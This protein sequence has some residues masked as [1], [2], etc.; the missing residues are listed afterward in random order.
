MNPEFREVWVNG[1]QWPEFTDL[2]E[3]EEAILWGD[4]KGYYWD[5]QSGAP[6][7]VVYLNLSSV[8]YESSIN[9]LEIKYKSPVGGE[10][11]A[12]RF[13]YG[14]YSVRILP[15]SI[16]LLANDIQVGSRVTNTFYDGFNT[17][18]LKATPALEIVDWDWWNISL[19]WGDQQ[20]ILGG[21]SRTGGYWFDEARFGFENGGASYSITGAKYKLMIQTT[22][23]GSYIS[24]VIDT[25]EGSEWE[26]ISWDAEVPAGCVVKLQTRTGIT[27]N[28]D[29]IWSGWSGYY[30]QSGNSI[31]SPS[32]RYI[33]YRV[34]LNSSDPKISPLMKSVDIDY[35]RDYVP[36]SVIEGI[37]GEGGD[38]FI[39]LAWNGSP[40]IDTA[41]YNIYRAASPREKINTELVTDL[42]YKDMGVTNGQ[43][44]SYWITALDINGNESDFQ[45]ES[46]VITAGDGTPP[47]TEI[48]IGE[49]FEYPNGE[50]LMVQTF[51]GIGG[52]SIPAWTG[53]PGWGR[54]T[55]SFDRIPYQS[56]GYMT[57]IFTPEPVIEERQ[58][59]PGDLPYPIRV[60]IS[61]DESDGTNFIIREGDWIELNYNGNET[62]K[63]FFPYMELDS[64]AI[65]HIVDGV[66]IGEESNPSA[67]SS[68]CVYPSQ[69]GSTYRDVELTQIAY[70]SPNIILNIFSETPISLA[71]IDSGSEVARIEYKIDEGAWQVYN[72]AFTLGDIA[73]GEYIIYY[74]STDNFDNIEIAKSKR[75]MLKT[76]PPLEAITDLTSKSRENITLTWTA[77]G[78]DGTEG[79][80]SGYILKYSTKSI[81]SEADFVSAAVYPQGWTPLPSGSKE[82]KVLTDFEIGKR[83]YFAITAINYS[84][85]ASEI[86]NVCSGVA[87]NVRY[88]SLSGSDENDGLTK[89]QPLA[90]IQKA[91]DSAAQGTKVV[92]TEGTYYDQTVDISTSIT[93]GNPISIHGSGEVILDGGGVQL[94]AFYGEGVS[95][96][97]ISDIKFKGYT[98]A[99]INII[100]S[101][102]TEDII[103]HNIK[104]SSCTFYELQDTAIKFSGVSSFT[105]A[106]NIFEMDE[107]KIAMFPLYAMKDVTIEN[108]IC[109]RSV[110][111]KTYPSS[112]G[113]RGDGYVLGKFVIK[114]NIIN[115]L[116]IGVNWLFVYDYEAGSGISI[117]GN[118]IICESDEYD[119]TGICIGCDGA[120]EVSIKDNYI[121]NTSRDAMNEGTGIKVSAAAGMMYGEIKRNTV[122]NFKFGICNYFSNVAILNNTV[123]NCSNGI[124]AK[125]TMYTNYQAEV[126]NNIV[127][128]YELKT[129]TGIV[130]YGNSADRTDVLMCNLVNNYSVPV[131]TFLIT[132]V[133]MVSGDPGFVDGG[134]GDCRLTATSPCI[135]AGDPSPEYNDPDGT[136]C[137]I[138]AYYY[139]YEYPAPEPGFNTRAGGNVIVDLDPYAK[140]SF[141]Y[142]YEQG[143]TQAV[144]TAIPT[145]AN[146][147]VVPEN[148]GYNITTSASF[149]GYITVGIKYPDEITGGKENNLKLL[150]QDGTEWI[151]IT[152]A[153]D[154]GNNI[155]YGKVANLSLFCVAYGDIL[156]PRTSLSAGEPSYV[157]TQTIYITDATTF[158]LAAVD[159]LLNVGDESGLGVAEIRYRIGDNP[160][161]VYTGTLSV[162]GEGSR[163]IAYYSVDNMGNTE[164]LKTSNIVVDNSP[165][166]IGSFVA[167]P[168]YFSPNGDGIKDSVN[169]TAALSEYA[170]WT[171]TIKNSN[172]TVVKTLTGNGE[173]T[174]GISALWSPSGLA[175]GDYSINIAVTDRLGNYTGEFQENFN[176]LSDNLWTQGHS[177]GLSSYS[178]SANGWLN[179]T[180]AAS[181]SGQYG[182]VYAVSKESKDLTEGIEFNVR[183]RVPTDQNGHLGKDFRNE[184]YLLPADLSGTDTHLHAYSNWLRVAAKVDEDNVNP[185][186]STHFGVHWM[187][188]RRV[189]G[190]LG[191]IYTSYSERDNPEIN[192]PA[193]MLESEWK[194]R[195]N[196]SGYISIWL[197][198]VDGNPVLVEDNAYQIHF[199]SAHLYAANRT[200]ISNEQFTVS[201]DYIK[202][203]DGL[204]GW[205]RVDLTK[206][207]SAVLLPGHN[208]Y[209]NQISSFIGTTQDNMKLEKVYVQ[210]LNQNEKLYWNSLIPEWT[211]T[212]VWN[213]V[214]FSSRAWILTAP[215][216]TNNTT[217]LVSSKAEDSAGNTESEGEAGFVNAHS[218]VFDNEPPQI[219]IVSPKAGEVYIAEKSTIK[220]DFSVTDAGPH[221]KQAYLKL[222]ESSQTGAIIGTMVT[223]NN[224]DELE[225]RD[226]PYYGFY[227][228]TVEAEDWAGHKSSSE[229]AK[230][231]V[232]WDIL[233]PRTEIGVS[234]E[235]IEIGGKEYVASE[236][237]FAL[238]AVDDLVE[239]GDEIGLGVNKTQFKIKNENLNIETDW[240]EYRNAFSFSSL[241]TE[242]GL[243]IAFS[244]GKYTIDYYSVDVIGNAELIQSAT[245]YLDST[246]PD[247]PIE[248]V[249]DGLSPSP[250]KNSTT[251]TISW[252][253]PD[254]F[255]GIAGAYYK[256][257][258]SPAT[259][260]DGTFVIPAMIEDKNWLAN[261]HFDSW[262]DTVFT[263]AGWSGSHASLNW[264]KSEDS[265]L[266][267][268]SCRVTAS[269]RRALR[270]W[271]LTMNKW[272]EY[273][274]RVLVKGKGKINLGIKYPASTY[275]YY[276]GWQDI[277]T[278]NWVAVNVSRK[279][280][281]TG[282]DGGIVIM[283]ESIDGEILFGAAW[284][285]NEE[286]PSDWPHPTTYDKFTASFDELEEGENTLYVWFEDNVGNVSHENSSTVKLRYD[287]TPPA[288]SIVSP[289]A[290][291]KF[292]AIVSTIT[293]NYIV[294]DNL[295]LAPQHTACLRNLQTGTSFYLYPGQQIEP[296]N[297]DA[298]F[299]ELCIKAKDHA[300]NMA[301][302]SGGP[303]EVIRDILPPRTEI[304][305]SG[306]RF[307]VSEKEYVTSKTSFSLTAVD[308]LIEVVD[309]A[310][311]GVKQ[312][313]Y[314]I[315]NTG[316]KIYEST[317]YI[318]GTDGIYR[319][320]YL[321]EDV[322]GNTEL[323]KTATYYLDNTA[324]ETAL[325]I[326]T[327]QYT[328]EGKIY[329]SEE[330]GITLSAID[331][332]IEETA[333]GVQYTEYRIGGAG[334]QTYSTPFTL[335]ASIRLVEYR[336]IDNVE[337]TEEIKSIMLYVDNTPP[338]TAIAMEGTRYANE[339][340]LYVT[341]ATTFT[342]TADDLIVEEVASGVMETKYRIL[343]S[344]G[345][346]DDWRICEPINIIGPDGI[347]KIEH[348]SVDN[349]LNTEI[350]KSI[351]VKLDNTQPETEIIASAPQYVSEGEIYISP[352]TQIELIALDP[353]INEVAVGV[354][355]VKYR[356][357]NSDWKICTGTFTL[358]EGV[359]TVE[360]YAYDHLKNTEEIKTRMYHVDGTPPMSSISAAEP[361]FEAFGL[362]MITPETQIGLTANDPEVSAVASG[363]NRIEYR[364]DPS[365]VTQTLWEVYTGTFTLAEGAHI[366]EY[367]SV[368]N[369]SNTETV[370]EAVYT[371]TY[372][373]EYAAYG[374]DGVK[375]S[376]QGEIFGNVRSNGEVKVAGQA[377]IAGDASGE[378]VE[379]DG[380]EAKITGEITE[381]SEKINP[382]C[383][384]LDAIKERVAEN[385][386]NDK[387]NLKDGKLQINSN[388]T[389]TIT[390]GTYYLSGINVTAKAKLNIE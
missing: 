80:A 188:Q 352:Q 379:L 36:P 63:I 40:D 47:I 177:S 317:F 12:F 222:V 130:A 9:T 323:T 293:V 185:N 156:P 88:V 324:P 218:F 167:E 17:F 83:Y 257:R 343:S 152:F 3:Y 96:L 187:V 390:S 285:S 79:T 178:I 357:D 332:V 322:I 49:P 230:F 117:E 184:F 233:P 133:S 116:N 338:V 57:V 162:A 254:A 378:T 70:P 19:D 195:I 287:I 54:P 192:F 384:D 28:T 364:I 316:Y 194:I 20:N 307:A 85:K 253:D 261:W 71:A 346:Y 336:S 238:T 283:T 306:E 223:V 265:L 11:G 199:S 256:L 102:G 23:T 25:K 385:N 161:Q 264:N 123:I 129:G 110:F 5:V 220:I 279:P 173:E 205:V 360:Y 278:D 67:H 295:D 260:I 15:Y 304:V 326:G 6:D 16:R 111:I 381:S 26:T 212:S 305:V 362:T 206:P 140:V 337:N 201:Y 91:V 313:R 2:A 263:P 252:A 363:V 280:T 1:E 97:E 75:V 239:V 48:T 160:W 164:I 69:D 350:V 18:K 388:K 207:E 331:P 153:R 277:D 124:T 234:G 298:G 275:V 217:Y 76:A 228:L 29:G 318:T 90:T 210:V 142:V 375:V 119:D 361:R 150:H 179:L 134:L 203:S 224:G 214:E 292:Y 172:A 198:D 170:D 8:Y 168:L 180:A 225:P 183:M 330:T 231:E 213:D 232:I 358:T 72:S 94:D 44:Y 60:G 65:F 255:S 382:W 301:E 37:T 154:T 248:L 14:G 367:R 288:I 146:Y 74:R 34:T 58:N 39:N 258:Q 246:A 299:W 101:G 333:S 262:D 77:V 229:T 334:W 43:T 59:E 197:N 371:V 374:E 189:N 354:E 309:G 30:T 10:D 165:P 84:S 369:V 315:R 226:L 53:V 121:I 250:W 235:R 92:I 356:I 227:T 136:R 21:T 157:D 125:G 127:S 271:G 82:T 267:E 204:K 245:Y 312:I 219:T 302:S 122:D 191:T 240:L 251:Y 365:T 64:Y 380:T 141:P 383:I 310:G 237:S 32:G 4:H 335:T 344:T 296:L 51:E 176:T 351:T 175:E 109:R 95:N 158:T 50:S 139:G 342:L 325:S 294:S 107:Y 7:I 118:T 169:I 151:D 93:S 132:N 98:Q 291:E 112:Y 35:H 243:L 181:I 87:G 66:Y 241:I 166:E 149:E 387:L 143:N 202:V 249:A 359:R 114:N 104:I 216:L 193:N 171:V 33:Q 329:I 174:S 113:V 24:K 68:E 348:Y 311:L 289:V 56:A 41:G 247:A 137:D 13:G 62:V 308:D 341:S 190:S 106:G 55:I 319:V 282:A 353:L 327:P 45:S 284:F 347:Y 147:K 148:T 200:E 221:T 105:V 22:T 281:N 138:G 345:V 108:N 186:S 46:V 328:E 208:K 376:G 120:G 78:S 52:C 61:L 131:D 340:G 163:V 242:Y 128:S 73:E 155:I 276:G 31:T 320:D 389:V 103:N 290:E 126:R 272:T 377:M 99:A 145:I 38:G 86:S 135:N 215:E 236:T 244:D 270:Q 349:L 300:G 42:F 209:Y 268:Y 81:N 373:S 314:Q 273:H 159:D 144:E 286:P 100:S 321:S 89:D 211:T 372:I 196:D 269:A 115:N 386:D 339:D 259:A 266:G 370:K 355:T 368:D 297:I 182:A 303:F 274:A 366:V 27:P